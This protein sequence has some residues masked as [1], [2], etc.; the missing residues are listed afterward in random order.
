MN[1]ME[2]KVAIITGAGSGIGKAAAI[3]FA[4]EAAKVVVTEKNREAGEEV[5][6]L[7]NE[8]GQV[9]FIETD[10]S[11]GPSVQNCIAQTVAMFG[12]LDIL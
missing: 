12:K 8:G 1:R 3:M 11:E 7:I 5:A 9:L 2:G 10:V 6:K 4:R